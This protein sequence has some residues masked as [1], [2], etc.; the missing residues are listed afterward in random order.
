[1]LNYLIFV[2]R[3]H[4]HGIAGKEGCDRGVCESFF[5]PNDDTIVFKNL[6]IQCVKRNE[7]DEALAFRESQNVDPFGS[8]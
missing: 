4:P 7:A 1:M 3:P 8:K 2:H 6:G 5:F